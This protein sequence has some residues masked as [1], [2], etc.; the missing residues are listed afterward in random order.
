M[1]RYVIGYK[2]GGN[3]FA[4][5]SRLRAEL[6]DVLVRYCRGKATLI[7]AATRKG[8]QISARCHNR[9]VSNFVN[10]TV[11]QD[12]NRL[13]MNYP[14]DTMRIDKMANTS[15]GGNLMCR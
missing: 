6:Y 13:Q 2:G 10:D 5:A 1:E 12:V 11:D 4:F 14:N 8:E 3:D 15:P 7:F 9:A